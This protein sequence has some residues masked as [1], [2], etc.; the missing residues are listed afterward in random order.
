M[1]ER[2]DGSSFFLELLM[3]IHMT[4]EL[5][6]HT[7]VLYQVWDTLDQL[8]I[9]QAR[10]QGGRSTSPPPYT[11]RGALFCPLMVNYAYL[12]IIVIDGRPD[13]VIYIIFT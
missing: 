12:C 1:F 11:I 4:K 10:S 3:K 6:P 13:F 2:E 7:Y 8:G 9:Q 5:S